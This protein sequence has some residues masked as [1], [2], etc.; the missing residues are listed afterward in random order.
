[1][2]DETIRLS[3][4]GKV[5]RRRWRA[6]LLLAVVGAGVGA[7]A[8]AVLSPGYEAQAS[9]LLQGPRQPDELLTQAQ[10]A[11]S[12]VVLDRASAALGLGIRGTD[13]QKSVGASVAQGNVVTITAKGSSPERS[14]QL[15]D[16]VAG[17]FVKYSTQLLG[18][19]ADQAAQLAQQQKEALRQQ[20]TQTN[21]RILDLS[22]SVETGDTVEGVQARTT[23][24]G[25]RTALEQAVN[26]LNAADAATGAG[27]MVVLGPS[28]RPSSPSAPTFPQLTVGGAVLFFV[29]GILAYLFGARTDRR[30]RAEGEIGAALGAP[31]L[32]SIDIPAGSDAP[33]K[34][35]RKAV[36]NDRP[37]NLPEV[38]ASADDA[39]REV[40]YR[41]VLARLGADRDGVLR[42]L[43]LVPRGDAS[44]R[45]VAEQFADAARGDRI[46]VEVAVTEIEVVPGAQ[47]IVPDGTAGVL[48]VVSLGSRNAWELV[49]ISEACSDA[50]HEILGAVLAREVHLAGGTKHQPAAKQRTDELAGAR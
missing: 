43:I 39:A 11:T 28:E 31:V 26:N 17:E 42:L 38:A 40:R 32:A 34:W 37:W 4:A 23:L 35:W 7:G 30:P 29:L 19:S 5:V 16:Q 36:G 49:S 24:Q 3:V 33:A 12:S 18:N 22:K 47:P 50:G 48:V 1:M 9:V 6:L 10:V 8:S 41:R 27:N 13:L 25:L 45:K 44:A 14:Q 15:A 2:S 20:I 21:Q 46:R